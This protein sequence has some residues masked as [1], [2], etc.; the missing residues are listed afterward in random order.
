MEKYKG[1]TLKVH[2]EQLG[3]LQENEYYYHEIIGCKVQ[4]EDGEEIGQIGEILSTGA[5]DV[6]IVKRKGK[7]DAL[8]PYIESVVLRVDVENKEVMIRPMEG[9]L[10]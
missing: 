8:I 2:E 10:E 4:A 7:K 3:A 1:S 6:W 5:N 9:L